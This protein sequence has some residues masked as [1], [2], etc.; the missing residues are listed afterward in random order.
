M[1]C[2]PES[3]RCHLFNT[4]HCRIAVGQRFVA[5]FVLTAFTGVT[6]SPQTVH[7]DR[8]R[9]VSFF[10]DR[11]KRHCRRYKTFHDA[12][13]RLDLLDRYAFPLF[14]IEQPANG[15]KVSRSV[16][17]FGGILKVCTFIPGTHCLLDESDRLRGQQMPFGI[18][19]VM[20]ISTG[21]EYFRT[22]FRECRRMTLTSLLS[23]DIDADTLN[24]GRGAGE[25]PVD[26]LGIETD[27]LE[28]LSAPIA[29]DG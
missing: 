9:F 22:L 3:S 15:A 25:I 12:V 11:A 24:S 13:Y 16:V 17:D 14:E 23:D 26:E 21:L 4:A 29:S 2:H 18:L 19:A 27:R 5:N 1:T 6:L 7:G 28:N 8:D 10:A 20:D